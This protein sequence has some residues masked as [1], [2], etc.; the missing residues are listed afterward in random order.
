MGRLDRDSSP[1]EGGDVAEDEWREP[2]IIITAGQAGGLHTRWE[3]LPNIHD[4]LEMLRLA[5][6]DVELEHR[7]DHARQRAAEAKD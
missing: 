6:V 5:A 1:A 4:V 2:T 7:Q 3:N